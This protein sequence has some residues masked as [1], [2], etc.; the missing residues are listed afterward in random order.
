MS[1]KLIAFDLDGTLLTDD[2]N[3]LPATI[4]AVKGLSKYDIKYTISS[5][6]MFGAAV[7][8]AKE[9][10]INLPL[11]CSNGTLLRYPHLEENFYHNPIQYSS[12]LWLYDLVSTYPVNAFYYVRDTIYSTPIDDDIFQYISNWTVNLEIVSNPKEYLQSPLTQL[13]LIAPEEIIMEIKQ[14]IE[15][16]TFNGE[17]L[18]CEAFASNKFSSYYLAIKREGTSK[19]TG[20][21]LVRKH[22]TIKRE[23]IAAVGDW[24][25]DLPMFEIAQVSV[26]MNNAVDEVKEKADFIT[27]RTNEENGVAEAIEILIDNDY[28]VKSEE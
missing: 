12:G 7:L 20:L 3:L 4:E 18:H 1:L 23:E 19:A 15:A 13:L 24:V 9:L 26:A 5:G 27:N 28:I 10:D 25:N 2:K 16:E 8:F 11:I 14:Y 21:E 17:K 6:R 22:L